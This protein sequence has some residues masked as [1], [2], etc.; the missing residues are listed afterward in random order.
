[1]TIWTFVSR[2]MTLLFNT[3]FGFVI[4]FLLGSNHLLISW[5]QSPSAVISEPKKR[6]SVTASTFSP[7]ICHEV[8]EPDAM[9]L[10]FLILSFKL[11]FSFSSFTLIKRFFS[12]SLLSA[13]RVVSSTYLRLL[14]FL[15]EILIPACNSSS[16]AFHMMWSMFKVN[17]QGDNKQTYHTP[18]SI[19]NQSVVPSRV[20]TVAF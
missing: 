8:M 4:A 16:P 20:V 18:F 10:V 14:I 17:K 15:P 13:V 3:L 9:V 7:S 5:L 1:M 19:L 2:V 6:K 12:S 11:A